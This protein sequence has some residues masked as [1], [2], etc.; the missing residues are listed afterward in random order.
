LP[1]F[2]QHQHPHPKEPE[3]NCHRS[4]VITWLSRNLACQKRYTDTVKREPAAAPGPVRVYA[5]IA[6]KVL[7]QTADLDLDP[8][9]LAEEVKRACAKQAIPYHAGIIQKAM[10][11]AQAARARRRA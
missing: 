6:A 9:T 7:E 2:A 4:R 11:A 10:D 8:G 1:R 3:S 5:A